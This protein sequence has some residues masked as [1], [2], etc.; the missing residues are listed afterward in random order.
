[1]TDK[2]K[3]F[4]KG[5]LLGLVSRAEMPKGEPVAYL[6]NGVRLP[7]LPEWD[8]SKY[9]YACIKYC[10]PAVSGG[11][12]VYH[13]EL[14]AFT[15]KV[16]IANYAF[17]PQGEYGASSWKYFPENT[18]AQWEFSLSSDAARWTRH[19]D[20]LWTNFELLRTD[21]TLYLAASEPTPVYE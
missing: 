14:F 16:Q 19:T 5:I 18:P 2:M 11:D 20:V 17:A 8:K 6:Y 7:K 12:E 13:Y 10:D 3:S 1:M 15:K 9:P 21:G 4:V